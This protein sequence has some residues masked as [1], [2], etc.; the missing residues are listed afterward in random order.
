LSLPAAHRLFAVIGAVGFFC[1]G[2]SAGDL[3]YFN[4]NAEG[5]A[6]DGYDLVAMMDLGEA[7]MG[8]RSFEVIYRGLTY[9][10]TSRKH[11]KAFKASPQK[12]LPQYGGWCAF[13]CGV[14]KAKFGFGAARFKPDPTSFLVEE[15]KLYL[16][17]NL[18]TYQ[19]KQLWQ[20]ADR[21]AVIQR[22]DAY[23]AKRVA[24]GKAIGDLPRGMNAAAPMETAQFAPLIGEW[25]NTVR[26]MLDLNEKKYGPEIEGTWLFRFGWDGFGIDDEWRQVGIPGSGGP[27]HRFFDPSSKKWVMVY[28]PANQPRSQIW[29]MEGGFDEKGELTGQFKGV[30]PRGREFLGRV[31]FYDIQKDRFLWQHDR[32]YDGGKTWIEKVAVSESVRLS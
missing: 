4:A 12:Y 27:A 3:W 7:S 16:F 9:R 23:W 5:V 15:G 32:S 14:D 2:L 20:K 17:A 11:R 29:S 22:A 26:W 28:M 8:K 19:A 21:A 25:S 13:T 18:P 10:F 6:I 1:S 31:R 24:L 30:D